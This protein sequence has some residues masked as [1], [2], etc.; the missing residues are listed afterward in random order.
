MTPTAFRTR[1]SS[2]HAK[3]V[4]EAP[5]IAADL[6]LDLETL[7]EKVIQLSEADE[8]EV[9]IHLT[10]DALTRF[11]NNTIHQNV[12]ERSLS[13]SVRAVVDGRTA[14]AT[15]NKIDLESLSAKQP[16]PLHNLARNRPRNPDLPP[17]LGPRSYEKVSRFSPATAAATPRSRAREVVKVCHL[18]QK[19]KQTA[20]GILS[21]A[22]TQ[23]LLLNSQGLSVRYQQ[24][25]A[26]FSVTILERDSSGWSKA[27]SSDVRDIDAEALAENASRQSGRIAESTR[28]PPGPLHHDSRAR[29]RPRSAWLSFLR[30][31]RNGCAR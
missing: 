6:R 30:L 22:S 27:T 20:A 7:G 13:I 3:S 2:R 16:P 14:R 17:M 8:T 21:T 18:A 15:T 11:A 9:S 24:T 12:A 1:K 5:H 19:A 10:S 25:R 4:A 31:R 23:S 28:T 26:E 29:R